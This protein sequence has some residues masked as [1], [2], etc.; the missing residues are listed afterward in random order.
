MSRGLAQELPLQQRD[1]AAA[2][3]AVGVVLIVDQTEKKTAFL[4]LR[5]F[6]LVAVAVMHGFAEQASSGSTYLGLFVFVG[7]VFVDDHVG[8]AQAA[9]INYCTGSSEGRFRRAGARNTTNICEP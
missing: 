2:V 4:L 5:C 8:Q 7:L 9:S 3:V 1:A 6:L